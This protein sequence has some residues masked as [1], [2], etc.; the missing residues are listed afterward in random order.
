MKEK[1]RKRCM[2]VSF[3]ETDIDWLKEESHKSG[4]SQAM[5]VRLA[6]DLYRWNQKAEAAA[7]FAEKYPITPMD[8]DPN[9]PEE[10]DDDED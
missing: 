2:S 10:P 8:M 5:I 9:D 3:L 6:L 4:R 1:V 7:I